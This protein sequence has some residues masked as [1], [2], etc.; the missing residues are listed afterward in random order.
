[1]AGKKAGEVEGSA[2][3]GEWRH[4]GRGQCIFVDM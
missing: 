1:M 3:T 4:R 2:Y